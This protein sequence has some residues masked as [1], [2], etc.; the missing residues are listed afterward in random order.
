MTVVSR[1]AVLTALFV[2]GCAE[3]K[4]QYTRDGN[5]YGTTSGSFRGRWWNYYER[6][7]SFSDGRFHKEANA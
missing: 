5:E 4:D 1:L 6:G 7:R 2:S 3:Q